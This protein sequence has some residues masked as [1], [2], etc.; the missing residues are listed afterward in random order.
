V[1]EVLSGKKVEYNFENKLG[2]NANIGVD[3]ANGGVKDMT[4]QGVIDLMDTANTILRIDH[5]I[6][7]KP[8]GGPRKPNRGHWDDDDTTW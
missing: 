8:A 6:M 3:I 2:N 1:E 5:I 7:K 4:K